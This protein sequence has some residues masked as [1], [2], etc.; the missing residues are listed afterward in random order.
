VQWASS[1]PAES[2]VK[3]EGLCRLGHELPEA[4]E[5]LWRRTPAPGVRGR[6]FVRLKGGRSVVR[7]ENLDEQE[8]LN[9]SRRDV[10]DITSHPAVLACCP[11]TRVERGSRLPGQAVAPNGLMRRFDEAV[12]LKRARRQGDRG[13][14]T[15]PS[16]HD[17]Q[18]ENF[19]A[20]PLG[21]P[22]DIQ[23][24]AVAE[25]RPGCTP[26]RA[27][28]PSPSSERGRAGFEGPPPSPG[29]GDGVGECGHQQRIAIAQEMADDQEDDW[30]EKQVLDGRSEHLRDLRF[31]RVV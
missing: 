19:P 10:Y 21:G 6:F 2:A 11:C 8:F 20:A 13:G 12:A 16:P 22:P 4:A 25:P 5:G 23:R 24:C 3:W 31:T 9:E 14:R 7:L 15:A 18:P 29:F 26:P 28:G 30:W 17:G 1:C 27:P